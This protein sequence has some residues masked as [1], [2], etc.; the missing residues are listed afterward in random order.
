VLTEY[1]LP[2]CERP[3]TF[4]M[5]MHDAV[6]ERQLFARSSRLESTYSCRSPLPLPRQSLQQIIIS[7]LE[8]I[9][10]RLTN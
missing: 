6:C 5:T 10:P 7:G 8:A 2:H 3:Q 1:A 9:L 4:V